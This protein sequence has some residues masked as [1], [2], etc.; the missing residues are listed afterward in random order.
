MKKRTYSMIG[1]MLKELEDG[2]GSSQERLNTYFSQ[3][4]MDIQSQMIADSLKYR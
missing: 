4:V 3:A 1:D 2:Y